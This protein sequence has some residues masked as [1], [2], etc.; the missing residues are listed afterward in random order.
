VDR[1]HQAVSVRGGYAAVCSPGLNAR[2]YVAADSRN[3]V[4]E[5]IPNLRTY[6]RAR[7]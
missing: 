4:R 2:E 1:Y 6:V 7:S 3:C 5:R